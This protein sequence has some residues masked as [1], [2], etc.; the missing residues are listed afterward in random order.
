M[1]FFLI[2][3]IP[4]DPAAVMLGEN[5][6]QQELQVLRKELGL[7][8]PL[9]VQFAIWL[10]RVA[11]GD[12]GVS[13]HTKIPVTISIGERFPVTL[14][15]TT[16]AMIFS[17]LIALPSGI[18]AAY[19]QNTRKDYLF[20]LGTILGV[21][22]PGYW[23][24]LVLLLVFSV[25][26]GWFPSTGFVSITE[27]FW[28][29]LRYLILPALSLGFLM[30]AVVARMIRSSMLE[31]LRLEYVTHARAKGL[32]EWKVVVL[33]ALKNAFAPTLTTIGIQYGLLLGGAVVT[34]AVFS[35]PGLGKYLV[36]SI[37]DRDYPVVQGCILFIA[38]IYV[39]VNLI[40]DLLYPFFDPRV[41]YH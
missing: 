26:L 5:V 15:L 10:G 28:E 30:A 38:L 14:S 33:H 6:N 7:D 41:E 8:R 13:I 32:T 39:I 21:S 3:L 22:V 34:E 19:Y 37:Y 16:L 4:G 27:D 2:H 18:L 1:V 12:F 29:G 20:M 24:G 25:N 23:L 40:V 9:P 11:H 31:V 17:L 35:L 36:V